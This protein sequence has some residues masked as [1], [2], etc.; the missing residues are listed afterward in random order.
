MSESQVPYPAKWHHQG[1]ESERD[2]GKLY[3][4][5]SSELLNSAE[6][7]EIAKRIEIGLFAEQLRDSSD[8]HFELPNVS[9]GEGKV[10]PDELDW[11]IQDGRDAMNR[12]IFS[13]VGLVVDIAK[14]YQGHETPFMDLVQEGMVGLIRAAQKFDYDRGVEFSTY[15]TKKVR[16]AIQQGVA[17]NA[18]TIYIPRNL[19]FDMLRMHK[20]KGQ[21]LQQVGREATL[22][23][24]AEQSGKAVAEVEQLLALP[25]DA[26]SFDEPVNADSNLTVAD[27]II[28][29]TG[30]EELGVEM[31][32]QEQI[33]NEVQR[34][35]WDLDERELR[36]IVSDFGIRGAEKRRDVD[37]GAEYGVSR[38]A[39]SLKRRSAMAKLGHAAS[40]VLKDLIA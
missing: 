23:E 29:D 28:S 27:Q 5:E 17:N 2:G 20:V 9:E 31:I 35:L 4:S 34:L 32:A 36:V 26:D 3:E 40:P 30:S 33:R 12:L 39:I 22:A 11:F 25:P 1:N 10:M 6:V 24:L 16:Q 15:A 37:I 8:I 13:N 14:F 21:F 7:S 19:Y 18:R 38:Q